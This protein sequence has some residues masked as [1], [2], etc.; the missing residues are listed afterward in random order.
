MHVLLTDGSPVLGLPNMNQIFRWMHKIT[1]GAEENNL[2]TETKRPMTTRK[3]NPQ[4]L[5]WVNSKQIKY[6]LSL[7]YLSLPLHRKTHKDPN[8]SH[9][10]NLPRYH[11]K[12]KNSKINRMKD[13][14]NSGTE[15]TKF[16]T[17]ST[18][19]KQISSKLNDLKRGNPYL[20][21][22]LLLNSL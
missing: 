17:F 16:I 6:Y 5:W 19:T 11:E 2:N 13:I 9:L 7:L 3:S 20:A 8:S 1:N 10:H 21:V 18:G 15:Y 12:N 22:A 4:T 14:N